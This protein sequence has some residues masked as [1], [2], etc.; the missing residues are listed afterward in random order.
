MT[1]RGAVIQAAH[2][3]ETEARLQR[4]H[5]I[6]TM[7]VEMNRALP[8]EKASWVH[9]DGS[10]RFCFMQAANREYSRR[11]GKGGGHIGAVAKALLANLKIL[12]GDE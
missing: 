5:I 4:D 3:A 1:T 7:S 9:E 6:V 12:E 2:Y 10:P 11:G 8:A